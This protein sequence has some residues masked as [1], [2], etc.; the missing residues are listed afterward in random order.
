MEDIM[1]CMKGDVPLDGKDQGSKEPWT[2][3]AS[4][5]HAVSQLT[6]FSG[7]GNSAYAGFASAT[8]SDYAVQRTIE[9]VLREKRN[10]HMVQTVSSSLNL[11][12]GVL[13]NFEGRPRD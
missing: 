3:S 2:S 6:K 7:S 5:S 12:E 11:K 4:A 9:V 8:D 1:L 10:V 13:E